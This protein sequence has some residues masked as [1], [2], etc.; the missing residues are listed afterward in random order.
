MKK[1][2][3]MIEKKIAHKYNLPGTNN[4][5]LNILFAVIV[6]VG[7]VMLSP[8]SK[9]TLPSS[10]SSPSKESRVKSPSGVPKNMFL[11]LLLRDILNSQPQLRKDC[12]VQFVFYTN[13]QG[14][15]IIIAMY[16]FLNL[17]WNY[18]NR[19]NPPVPNPMTFVHA[20][21]IQHGWLHT[22]LG[23]TIVHSLLL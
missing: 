17:G 6:N 19:K 8:L 15:E 12:S 13:L 22:N 9:V 18:K 5:Q 1:I 23:S 2:D 16:K 11:L 14:V 10:W 20:Q 7:A 21:Y 4:H 3:S